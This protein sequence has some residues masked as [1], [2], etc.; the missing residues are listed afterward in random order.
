MAR[1]LPRTPFGDWENCGGCLRVLHVGCGKASL[2]SWL[3]SD[4]EVRVDIDPSMNPDVVASMTDLGDVGEFDCVYSAHCLE[5]LSPHEV[6]IAIEEFRRV[7]KPGGFALVIVPDLTDVK[8][9]H[10]ILY[11]APVGPITGHDVYFG[12][13]PALKDHPHMAHKCGFVPETMQKSLEGA[14]FGRVVIKS[15]GAYQLVGV[16]VK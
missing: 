2:P 15:L 5:H 4:E 14:G 9:T 11:E 16:A 1:E 12:Y 13:G 8:P 7:L 3:A 10:D 6:P